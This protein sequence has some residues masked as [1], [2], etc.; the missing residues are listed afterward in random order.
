MAEDRELTRKIQTI[1]DQ[2]DSHL[3]VA[4][5]HIE[6]GREVMICADDLFPL[7]SAVKVPVLVE[8]FRQMQ[9]GKLR[10]DDRWMLN[11]E[12]KNLGSGILTFLDNGLVPSVRDYLTLMI[13]ISDNTATDVLMER[14]CVAAIDQH[15]HEMGLA[16]THVAFRL[17]ELFADM[18]PNADPAQDRQALARWQEEHGVN[19]SGRAYQLGP[20]NNVST[21]G[22][23][24]R[25]MEMIFKAEILDRAACDGVLEILLKQQLNDRLPRFLP[26]GTRVAHKTGTISGVR[27][28]SGIIYINDSSHVIVTTF[29]SWDY[30]SV[31][32]D[33]R[34]SW[35]RFAQLDSAMGEI[36]LAAYENFA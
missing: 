21:P 26:Q 13:I 8:A 18:L 20:E 6:S 35:E 33:R 31:R 9:E 16:N 28:D 1:V 14:L 15:T 10:I 29:C 34:K 36:G 24:T 3:G 12:S 22:E 11:Q 25:L 30:D 7:A 23:F 27:N 32:K 5:R 2:S 4:V 17:K 19:R